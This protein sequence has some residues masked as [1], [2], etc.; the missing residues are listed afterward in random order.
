MSYK[1]AFL[2]VSLLVL[3]STVF[4]GWRAV[5]PAVQEISWT[6]AP[7]DTLS[8]RNIKIVYI[9]SNNDLLWSAEELRNQL[10]NVGTDMPEIVH[11]LLFDTTISGDH[12]YVI[13]LGL[14]GDLRRVFRQDILPMNK[15]NVRLIS[16]TPSEEEYYITFRKDRAYIAASTIRGIN[17]GVCSFWQAVDSLGSTRCISPATIVDYPTFP[18]R[19]LGDPIPFHSWS[20]SQWLSSADHATGILALNRDLLLYNKANGLIHFGRADFDNPSSA[21]Q[22]DSVL[23]ILS[24]GTSSTHCN[25]WNSLRFDW[26]ESFFPWV[27]DDPAYTNHR[28]YMSE[29][30]QV[31]KTCRIDSSADT[32]W[33][34]PNYAL[35]IDN[36]DFAEYNSQTHH[37]L[38]WS[39]SGGVNNWQQATENGDTFSRVELNS[40][41][42][43]W[44]SRS[45]NVQ[46][47]SGIPARLMIFE[48]KI[49]PNGGDVT[50]RFWEHYDRS[51]NGH[52]EVDPHQMQDFHNN[53][54][55]MIQKQINQ[56]TQWQKLMVQFYSLGT[57]WDS[58]QIWI[59][60]GPTG[61]NYVDIDSVRIYDSDFYHVYPME[62]ERSHANATIFHGD[63]SIRYVGNVNNIN[64]VNQYP[65]PVALYGIRPRARI[66]IDQNVLS[67]IT[68]PTEN[69]T[70]K[71]RYYA[72]A[73]PK[74]PAF[75]SDLNTPTTATTAPDTLLGWYG[76][77]WFRDNNP[78]V[79]RDII[80][81]N[82]DWFENEMSAPSR[83]INLTGFFNRGNEMRF[84]GYMQADYDLMSNPNGWRSGADIWAHFNSVVYSKL[85]EGHAD[86]S[87]R[88]VLLYADMF[89]PCHNSKRVTYYTNPFGPMNGLMVDTSAQ[90]AIPGADRS[91]HLVFVD[92]NIS[93]PG[94]DPVTRVVQPWE[95][96]LT[97]SPDSNKWE[98]ML[99]LCP[100]TTRRPDLI[101]PHARNMSEAAAICR[102]RG[103]AFTGGGMLFDGASGY[104][105]THNQDGRNWETYRY[106][107]DVLR[108]WW[109]EDPSQSPDSNF[110]MYN[111]CTQS[112]AEATI[113]A[114]PVP[115]PE[116]L[117]AYIDSVVLQYRFGLKGSWMTQQVAYQKDSLYHFTVDLPDAGGV[118]EYRFWAFDDFGKDGGG[119][120]RYG[121][122]PPRGTKWTDPDAGE[123][124]YLTFERRKTTPITT[125]ETFYAPG[126][127]SQK[128]Y[129]EPGGSVT[130]Q[131]LPGYR[132]A[133]MY[134]GSNAQFT[135]EGSTGAAARLVVAGT[136]SSIVRFAH[137]DT[138]G[139]WTALTLNAGPFAICSLRYMEASNAQFGL[140]F[141]GNSGHL[142]GTSSV[143]HLSGTS[144][145]VDHCTFDSCGVGAN[146]NTNATG[147]IKNST[148]NNNGTG[149]SC[150]AQSSL[151]LKDCTLNNNT[152]C[153]LTV[154]SCGDV[155][156]DSVHIQD[157][158]TTSSTYAGVRVSNLSKLSLHCC[159]IDSNRA[160]GIRALSSAMIM[161]GTR[162]LV[163]LGG[164]RI[165]NNT[166][167]NAASAS[168]IVTD[169]N[170]S[171]TLD[172]GNNTIFGH[173][174]HW[175]ENP[176][177]SCLLR[178][179]GN[180]WGAPCT[181]D[182]EAIRSHLVAVEVPNPGVATVVVLSPVATSVQDCEPGES[183][184]LPLGEEEFVEGSVKMQNLQDASARSDFQQVLSNHQDCNYV[185]SAAASILLIDLRSD[186]AGASTAYFGALADTST[187]R[188]LAVAA[189][190]AQAWSKAYS[191]QPDDA[192]T[193][194][195]ALL[196]SA[197]NDTE[198]V[199]AHLDLLS[200]KLVRQNLDTAGAVMPT[201]LQTVLDSMEYWHKW[202]TTHLRFDLQQGEVAHYQGDSLQVGTTVYLFNDFMQAPADTITEVGIKFK[203]LPDST[204]WTTYQTDVASTDSIYHWQVPVGRM[205]GLI[206]YIFW[207][208][209]VHGRYATSPVGADTANP[210]SGMTHFL[211]VEIGAD[212]IRYP[213]SV[214]VWAPIEFT[215]DIHLVDGGILVIKP[216]LGAT[217]HTVRMGDS[218][219]IDA[220]VMRW[221]TI[222]NW[223]TALRQKIY[224]LGTEEEP[225]LFE[226]A[227]SSS[228]DDSAG[229]GGVGA[230]GL[231]NLY[232]KHVIFRTSFFSLC[233]STPSLIQVDS[234]Q[235]D[236]VTSIAWINPNWDDTA[237]YVRHTEFS[238]VGRLNYDY[239]GVMICDGHLEMSDCRI[240]DNA[241]EGLVLYSTN[242]VL[243]RVLVDHN[244][245]PGLVAA[246]ELSD[247][248][249]RCSEFAFNGD[250]LPEA[251]IFAGCHQSFDNQ[252]GC[253]FMD[254]IGSLLKLE[255]TSSG[256]NLQDGGN[257]FYLLGGTGKYIECAVAEDT[258]DITGNF[259]YPVTPDSAEFLSYLSPDSA[260]YWNLTT[261]ADSFVACGGMEAGL[262]TTMAP[263]VGVGDLV[264]PTSSVNSGPTIATIGRQTVA[265]P[266]QGLMKTGN[267]LAA[268]S[269]FHGLAVKPTVAGVSSRMM[270]DYLNTARD[271]GA[272]AGMSAYYALMESQLPTAALRT[273][274]YWLQLKCLELEGQSQQALRGYEELIGKPK[275]KVDSVSAILS[276]MRLHFAQASRKKSDL[277]SMYPQYRVTNVTELARQSFRLVRSL[278]GNEKLAGAG[279]HAAPIPKAYKLYQN[280][281]NPFNPV[282]EIRFDVPEKTRVELRIFNILGQRVT[283]LVDEVRT[284]G[285]YHILWE[286]KSAGGVPVSSG[287]YIYQLKCDKFVD[288]KKMI[289]LR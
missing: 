23:D 103:L 136:D 109:K 90:V 283:T 11:V 141:S 96:I 225:I 61:G 250:T 166:A 41:A 228:G 278:Y 218:A 140:M 55:V 249:V 282:T 202:L 214:V 66:W 285:A 259:W 189:R 186:S 101:H 52:M 239:G 73:T 57:P 224:L 143:F 220:N 121:S 233:V 158:G 104:R 169:Q 134:V 92:W 204:N 116:D 223:E 26:F 185:Q 133:T 212:T 176:S 88:P 173:D 226:P 33:I 265:Q 100:D 125:A 82:M 69:L 72:Y 150:V 81:D 71:F 19:Y 20:G 10:H 53:Q 39:D 255:Y 258:L 120:G 190:T 147:T 247:P 198:F 277:A 230:Y 155:I 74:L 208:K 187:S 157:N 68:V 272:R 56:S 194:L 253:V 286:G 216:W 102:E 260:R 182:T 70:V 3:T 209:D 1:Y 165:A 44:I 263:H 99:A 117:V 6:G 193:M 191:G 267:H 181:T 126:V 167:A 221:D 132:Y 22:I 266:H 160:P 179:R 2:F 180:C 78:E 62:D 46:P 271:K 197:R 154:E 63:D 137:A 168:E 242:S 5:K 79:A 115:Y 21:L 18:R 215:H 84:G 24:S 142:S 130:I 235:F 161:A 148:F 30:I 175:I 75:I 196:D 4:P 89:N 25:S 144:L 123:R 245:G 145:T 153:G 87:L 64:I 45:F 124:F 105:E 280:Y 238:R 42:A 98:V 254:S 171:L 246:G 262:P 231:T 83:R 31:E 195:Q 229:W 67:G 127:I 275:S 35:A 232:A 284:A 170:S 199:Q 106:F 8:Q 269:S 9:G 59:Y 128:Y 16:Q 32:L 156:L 243:E 111:D 174:A 43:A 119:P 38:N 251:F 152:M 162:S 241:Y 135:L 288:A 203:S 48:F 276:A 110:R 279:P 163:P 219:W 51:R 188:Q 217:D 207:A 28:H 7:R 248:N 85:N 58:I 270:T 47:D 200:L 183:V 240:H 86:S 65:Y 13:F 178:W 76:A 36:S 256:T 257:G 236:S 289:L 37:F 138:S 14:W 34:V 12:A 274:A 211:S 244:H 49:R 201:Q 60:N 149:I 93:D 77:S 227:T 29:A 273:Q 210:D 264:A 252:A 146:L 108:L 164:N 222:S 192:Q 113:R 54:N 281:P 80:K 159:E 268:T 91:A 184:T 97:H 94:M 177:T 129:I 17:Y 15:Q 206:N 237:S 114:Y 27:G 40:N 205:G 261:Y 139:T 131:P 122:Y 213:D 95:R 151:K 234:C 172:W 112:Q 50:V 107:A 287:M 118:M